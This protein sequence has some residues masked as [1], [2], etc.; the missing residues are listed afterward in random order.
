[1]KKIIIVLVTLL[2]IVSASL[3]LTYTIETFKKDKQKTKIQVKEIDIYYES[4][5]ENAKKF[6]ELKEKYD[7]IIGN[8]YYSTV[9]EKK[10]ELLN[11]M[12]EYD[13]TLTKLKE[14]KEYL[15]KRCSIYY[16]NV[17]TRNKCNSYKI[18]YNQA[19]EVFKKDIELYSKL[20]EEYNKWSEE[21]GKKER[22]EKFKTNNLE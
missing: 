9:E 16:E 13:D 19:K 18:S 21:K 3:G 11:T 15:E 14:E 6:N 7:E 2:L 5:N 17:E 1:M 22:L 4:F 20:V 12:K 8:I 10:E